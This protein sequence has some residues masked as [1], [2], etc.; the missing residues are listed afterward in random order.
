MT[1]EQ[2]LSQLSLYQQVMM[3]EWIR[4][5]FIVRPPDQHHMIYKSI[6]SLDE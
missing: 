1:W 4:Q 2:N 6:K 3:R 5:L